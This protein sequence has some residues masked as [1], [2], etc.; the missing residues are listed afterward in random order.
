MGFRNKWRSWI[1]DC[2]SSSHTSIIVN[3]SPTKEFVI[4]KGV[5]KGDPLSPFLFII[6]MEG[7]NMA[8]KYATEKEIFK[9]IKILRN[10]PLISNLFYADD[11]PFAG[12]WCQSNLKNLSRILKCFHVTSSLIMNFHKSKVY[13][14]WATNTETSHWVGILGCEAGSLSFFYLGVPVDANMNLERSWKPIVN[15][16]SI[17]AL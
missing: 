4:T 15:K 2:L 13:G 8:L 7:L 10:G 16:I 12:E 1:K 5:K 6:E 9:V 3:V 17:Q 14:I 11:E